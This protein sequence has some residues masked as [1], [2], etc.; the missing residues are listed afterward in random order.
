MSEIYN[1]FYRESVNGPR[2][3][4]YTRKGKITEVKASNAALV[5]IMLLI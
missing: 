2:V 3:L 5:L 4:P 1:P